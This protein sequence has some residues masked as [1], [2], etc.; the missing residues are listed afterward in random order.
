MKN[1]EKILRAR[2]KEISGHRMSTDMQA[3]SLLVVEFL[4]TPERYCMESTFVTGVLSLKDLTPSP[5]APAFVTGVINVRGKIISI[6]NLKIL[7]GLKEKGITEL[8]KIILLKH[9]QMEFGIVTDAIAGTR[10][11]FL[12]ELGALPVTIKGISADY[13]KGITPDGLILL[14][15]EHL[16]TNKTIVVNQK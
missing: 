5:G 6:V 7:F 4:L 15:G 11:I 13:I 3:P 10:R 9:E 8:N 12:N 1:D 2:A 14:D 16:L